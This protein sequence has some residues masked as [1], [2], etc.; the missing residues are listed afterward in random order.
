MWDSVGLCGVTKPESRKFHLLICPRPSTSQLWTMWMKKGFHGHKNKNYLVFSIIL[1]VFFSFFICIRPS[2]C[3][4]CEWRRVSNFHEHSSQLWWYVD[5]RFWP[6]FSFPSFCVDWK[7]RNVLFSQTEL[8]AIKIWISDKF[9][10]L[11]DGWEVLIGEQIVEK[12]GEK[13][14]LRRWEPVEWF[15]MGEMAASR[16]ALAQRKPRESYS[17]AGQC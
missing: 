15:E 1:F 12:G 5:F 8:C 11:G 10:W 2:N 14:K 6:V 16:W 9:D 7:T 17:H 3:G 4:P 13:E